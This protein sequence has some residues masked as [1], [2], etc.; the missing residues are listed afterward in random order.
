M[1]SDAGIGGGVGTAL[2]LQPVKEPESVRGQ[3]FV[4]DQ[5]QRHT[6]NGS[7]DSAERSEA[8]GQYQVA[9]ILSHGECFVCAQ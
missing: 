1:G 8:S 3:T 5:S 7:S 2:A 4:H 9:M 6:C